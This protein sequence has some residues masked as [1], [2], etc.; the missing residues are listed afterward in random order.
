MLTSPSTEFP[1][2]QRQEH[3]RFTMDTDSEKPPLPSD[4]VASSQAI[5]LGEGRS[6]SVIVF[7]SCHFLTLNVYLAVSEKS[8]GCFEASFP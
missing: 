7:G 3:Q 8:S 2:S 5:C 4:E 6:D 1:V